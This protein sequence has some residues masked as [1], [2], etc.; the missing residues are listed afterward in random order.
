[1]FGLTMALA[2]GEMPFNFLASMLFRSVMGV[3]QQYTASC[4]PCPP[5]TPPPH[6]ARLTRRAAR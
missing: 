3:P 5:P 6:L 4:A 1:M 2:V